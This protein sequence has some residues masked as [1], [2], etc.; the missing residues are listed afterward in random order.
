M[1]RL[2]HLIISDVILSLVIAISVNAQKDDNVIQK[3]LDNYIKTGDPQIV[4]KI[5]QV[6]PDSKYYR[7]C[8][9]Y[10]YLDIDN[11]DYC[12][13]ADIGRVCANHRRFS[14]QSCRNHIAR[15]ARNALLV[16]WHPSQEAG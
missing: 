11:D 13:F 6:A 16:V 1:K 14:E 9:A 15:R 4:E 12:A 3:Y 7:F 2:L 5:R 10:D 8:E